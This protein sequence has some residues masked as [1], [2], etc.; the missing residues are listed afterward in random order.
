VLSEAIVGLPGLACCNL[1][2]IVAISS[3]DMAGGLD[4]GDTEFDR[5]VSLVAVARSAVGVTQGGVAEGVGEVGEL[6]TAGLQA[7][8]ANKQ[9]RPIQPGQMKRFI[10][11][12]LSIL[13]IF[14]SP[15][16]NISLYNKQ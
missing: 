5:P 16:T 13:T 11:F 10:R 12:P 2:S 3:G 7:I 4:S 8:N 14:L 1:A 9:T 15:I 6:L